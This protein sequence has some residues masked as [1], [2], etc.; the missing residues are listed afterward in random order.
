MPDLDHLYFPRKTFSWEVQKI[1]GNSS[2]IRCITLKLNR[3]DR[4]FEISF[5]LCCCICSLNSRETGTWVKEKPVVMLQSNTIM[6]AKAD[7]S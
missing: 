3:N 5:D 7:S 4:K 6:R 1:L 2:N